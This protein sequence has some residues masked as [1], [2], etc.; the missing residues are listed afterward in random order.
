MGSW[1]P[2]NYL[3]LSGWKNQLG[4]DLSTS[5]DEAAKFFDAAIAQMVMQDQDP[6][7]GMIKVYNL[8]FN[9]PVVKS[10]K[11]DLNRNSNHLEHLI[12]ISTYKSRNQLFC[13]SNHYDRRKLPKK[14]VKSLKWVK[15]SGQITKSSNRDSIISCFFQKIQIGIGIQIAN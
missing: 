6:N 3:D 1:F 15:K 2:F 8:I 4:L 7:I 11:T 14:Y 13:K 5:S 10:L 12:K 9:S